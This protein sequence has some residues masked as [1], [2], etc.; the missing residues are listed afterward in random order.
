MIHLTVK[1]SKRLWAGHITSQGGE[2]SRLA[3]RLSKKEPEGMPTTAEAHGICHPAALAT[4][5]Q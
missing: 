5:V 4:G 1:G 3:S 2:E